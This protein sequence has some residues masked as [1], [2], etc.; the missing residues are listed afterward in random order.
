MICVLDRLAV[1]VHSYSVMYMYLVYPCF[2]R[3]E[4]IFVTIMLN[5]G[6]CS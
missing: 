6:P 2:V 3:F 5:D 1:V 4:P